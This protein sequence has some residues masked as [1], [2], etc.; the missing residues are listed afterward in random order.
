V[1]Y[2]TSLMNAQKT[3]FYSGM[4]ASYREVVTELYNGYDFEDVGI[5]AAWTLSPPKASP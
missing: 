5:G 3:T 4:P 1:V 2:N